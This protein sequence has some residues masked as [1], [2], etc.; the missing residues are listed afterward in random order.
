M[1]LSSKVFMGYSNSKIE[2]FLFRWVNM[3]YKLSIFKIYICCI[4]LRCGLHV[5]WRVHVHVDRAPKRF[6][7]KKERKKEKIGSV[8][9]FLFDACGT[10]NSF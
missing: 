2:S 8:M 1:N 3:L 9:H 4:R 6:E 10:G 7:K 5:A